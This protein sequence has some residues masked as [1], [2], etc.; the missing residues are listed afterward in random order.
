LIRIYQAANLPQAHLLAGLL[1]HA[2][3][4]VRVFNENAQGGMGDIPFGET[5]PEIWIE[6]AAD[7]AK[8]IG[9]IAAFEAAP[10]V[11]DKVFCRACSEE[12]PANFELCWKC[13]AAL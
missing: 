7:K 6:D 10:L 9:V 1:R 5:Y 3:I 2:G 13:G 4:A 8:A 12:N 11:Q